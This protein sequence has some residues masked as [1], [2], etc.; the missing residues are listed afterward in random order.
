VTPSLPPPLRPVSTPIQHALQR[1]AVPDALLETVQQ[2]LQSGSGA[3]FASGLLELLQ[4]GFTVTPEDCARIPR[5]GAV[6]VVA[7]HYGIVEGLILAVI[8]DAIRSD[9][10]LV[11]NALL[12]RIDAI[13]EHTILVNPFGTSAANTENRAPLRNCIRWLSGGGLLAVLPA[14]E[15]AHLN[16]AEHSVVESCWNTMAAR[17]AMQSRA[18]VIPVFFE[19]ANSLPFQLAG[20]FHPGLRTIGLVREF[21]K[22]RGRSVRVRLG[23]PIPSS[24]L[25]QQRTAGTATEYLRSRTLFLA[26]RPWPATKVAAAAASPDRRQTHYPVSNERLIAREV[27]ALEASAELVRHDDFSVYLARSAQIPH[28]LEEIGRTREQAFRLVGEGTGREV[29][30]DWFDQHYFHLFLWCHGDCRL[31]GAY[32][33]ALTQDVLARVGVRGLYTNTLFQYKPEL[34]ARIGPS[35]ELGRS[36]VRFDYQ[37][38]YSP[39][40]L[41]W[42]GIGRFVH[43]HPEAPT[44]F[45][46][47][48]ISRPY[49]AASR[50]LMA[51]YLSERL[52]TDF[53]ALVR[54]RHKWQEPTARTR[55]VKRLAGAAATI[56]DI[57]LSI[58]DIEKDGKGVPVLIRQ[59]LKIGGKVISFSVDPRFSNS[60]DALILTDLRDTP[61]PVLERF[62]GRRAARDFLDWHTCRPGNF[63]RTEPTPGVYDGKTQR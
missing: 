53:T 5:T 28:L 63:Q 36:F 55:I 2:A 4:I 48:S 42:K 60:V 51:S 50:G 41:L 58:S 31:A 57:S 11:A 38:S 29:D 39:L 27:A 56:E 37:K 9:Y 21:M 12:S 59:Y 54:P 40:L 33:M 25:S 15:V 22:L 30:L 8:F 6:V 1:W 49:Q 19:G 24:V 35:V 10:K 26:N 3:R 44:L 32:R 14:G 61:V 18:P 34:F 16:F 47:V 52:L 43:E 46:A 20:A 7:N 45:G 17:L 13:A 23:N 62:M